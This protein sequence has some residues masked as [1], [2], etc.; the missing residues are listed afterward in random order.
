LRFIPGAGDTLA[1]ANTTYSHKNRLIS[2]FQDIRADVIVV[3]IGAGAS[4]HALCF[5]L[6]A[7]GHVAVATPDPASVLDLYRFIK[8]AAI[9]RVLPMFL[10]RDVV[11]EG[12]RI[13]TAA[14]WKRHGKLRERPRNPHGCLRNPLCEPFNLSLPSTVFQDEPV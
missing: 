12:L 5:F 10:M 2:S 8:L 14:A 11:A 6:M 1:T 3:D 9:R 7:D 13:E 4:Y